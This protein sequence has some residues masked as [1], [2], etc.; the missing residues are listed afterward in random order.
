MI[1]LRITEYG[2][3]L[4]ASDELTVTISNL[5]QDDLAEDDVRMGLKQL[6]TEGLLNWHG[7]QIVRCS[8]AQEKRLARFY[9]GE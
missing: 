2:V 3:H 5:A 9:E 6:V 4:T 7:E 1:A 8:S